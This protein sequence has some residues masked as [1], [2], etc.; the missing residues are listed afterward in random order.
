MSSSNQRRSRSGTAS[1]PG[2]W[3]HHT[4]TGLDQL[5]AAA[6]AYLDAVRDGDIEG[7]Y[8]QLCSEVRNNTTLDTFRV[9][10]RHRRN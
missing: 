2:T 4:S 10:T 5:P 9:P 7:A 1:N 6:S 3:Y 8:Q